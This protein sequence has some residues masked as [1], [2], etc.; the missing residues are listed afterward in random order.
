MLSLAQ[1]YFFL[2]DRK[3]S[4][5]SFELP[6][7]SIGKCFLLVELNVED[8]LILEEDDDFMM[9]HFLSLEMVE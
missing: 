5:M 1:T 9:L 8:G 4:G 7:T 6:D 2:E 3:S